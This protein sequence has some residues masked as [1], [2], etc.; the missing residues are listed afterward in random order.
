MQIPKVCPLITALRKN[1]NLITLKEEK[2]IYKT[3]DEVLKSKPIGKEAAKTD[4][5]WRAEYREAKAIEDAIRE[6][7]YKFPEPDYTDEGYINLNKFHPKWDPYGD[8]GLI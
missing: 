6:G 3:M 2:A 8:D 7:T 4:A 5:W 1:P